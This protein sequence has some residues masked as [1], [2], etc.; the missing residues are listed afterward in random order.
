MEVKRLGK[1]EERVTPSLSAEVLVKMP[2]ISEHLTAAFGLLRE[3]KVEHPRVSR[4]CDARSVTIGGETTIKALAK[5][6]V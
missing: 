5:D 4:M 1:Q 2:L 3:V 6:L